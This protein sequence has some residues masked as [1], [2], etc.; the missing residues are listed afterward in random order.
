MYCIDDLKHKLKIKDMNYLELAKEQ[1][2]TLKEDTLNEDR[3]CLGAAN[4]KDYEIGGVKFSIEVDGFWEKATW[5]D[6]TVNNEKG[7]EISK[8]TEY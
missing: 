5:F 7:E 6:W 4:K 1:F 3:H 2:Y 8:G